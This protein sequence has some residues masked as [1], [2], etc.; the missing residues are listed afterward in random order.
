MHIL[1]TDLLT[2]PRCGPE[3]GLIVLSEGLEDRRVVEGRLGCANCRSSYPI[4]RGVADLRHARCAPMQASA[5]PRRADSE[6]V[7]RIAALLGINRP[8]A[9]VLLLETDGSVA[10]GFSGL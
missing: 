4:R 10:A 6:R 1:L 3:F 7:M 9:P 5:N 2:C 8:G